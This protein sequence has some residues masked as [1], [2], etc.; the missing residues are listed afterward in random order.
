LLVNLG[1]ND[2]S[3]PDSAM[4]MTKRM[5]DSDN[6]V[7]AD[8]IKDLLRTEL[9]SKS[10]EYVDSYTVLSYWIL[11]D[12]DGKRLERLVTIGKAVVSEKDIDFS[13]IAKNLSTALEARAN[14][15]KD[16]ELTKADQHASELMQKLTKTE[17]DKPAEKPLKAGERT[18]GESDVFDGG[19]SVDTTY[20]SFDGVSDLKTP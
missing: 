8:K 5:L 9:T 10:Q 15:H 20:V 16:R 17:K 13:I 3:S 1:G 18:A 7:F 6:W 19:V 4:I 12:K 14:K 11:E 2:M